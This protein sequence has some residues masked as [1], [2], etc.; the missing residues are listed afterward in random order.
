MCKEPRSFGT[1]G[2]WVR[3]LCRGCG[4]SSP[5]EV[6]GPSRGIGIQG[7][8]SPGWSRRPSFPPWFRWG[9]QLRKGWWE[10][11]LVLGVPSPPSRISLALSPGDGARDRGG[12]GSS[13]RLATAAGP[14]QRR[15]RRERRRREPFPRPSPRGRP[16]R[17]GPR[18]RPHRAGRREPGRAAP[19][20]AAPAPPPLGSPPSRP[21]G[22]R[23]EVRAGPGGRGARG[24]APRSRGRACAWARGGGGEAAAAAAAAPSACSRCI[25]R[26]GGVMVTGGGQRRRGVGNWPR[27]TSLRSARGRPV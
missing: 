11:R 15:Q 3:G 1:L 22:G 5:G 13:G 8:S 7:S 2:A 20:P 23:C 25:Y 26:V 17:P 27:R 21:S 18:R 6:A 9:V 14:G 19:S 24:G 4:L 12:H 10:A 16:G